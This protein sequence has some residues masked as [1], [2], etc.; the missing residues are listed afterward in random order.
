MSIDGKGF[1]RIS[2]VL[3]KA[4]ASPPPRLCRSGP[5]GSG[6]LDR[7][8]PHERG[9]ETARVPGKPRA[10]S[11]DRGRTC[12]APGRDGARRLDRSQAGRPGGVR[13][14]DAPEGRAERNDPRTGRTP[15]RDGAG[16]GREAGADAGRA[17]PRRSTV[18][19]EPGPPGRS[20]RPA[21]RRRGDPSGVEAP[22]SG[23][24][25]SGNRP[26]APVDPREAR[27]ARGGA[28]V[29]RPFGRGSPDRRR[30][31]TPGR[32]GAAS[33]GGDGR[34]RKAG[35]RSRALPPSGRQACR[36]SG[37]VR[38]RHEASGGPARAA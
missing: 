15:A 5:A 21:G 3:G 38:F 7:D 2:P 31:R 17:W 12:G 14:R 32:A 16:V 28:A 26:T 27:H 33:S 4:V 37:G 29:P 24:E 18:P 10:G 8:D 19:A 34:R 13:R 30:R 25:R 20:R 6:A 11:A 35:R 1:R 22:A 9:G 23:A 36:E